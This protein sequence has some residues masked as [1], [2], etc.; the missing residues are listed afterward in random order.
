VYDGKD[1]T[2]VKG[3]FNMFQRE[4]GKMGIVVNAPS[5]WNTEP[6]AERGLDS[7][8]QPGNTEGGCVT[9]PLASFLTGFE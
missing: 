8:P 7:S 9:L 5:K 3:F 1:E 6:G 2:V 4:A